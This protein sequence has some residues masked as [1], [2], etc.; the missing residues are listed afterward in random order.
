[1]EEQN[2]A[3]RA[4]QEG[5]NSI[6]R[7]W[8]ALE[9]AVHNQWGGPTSSEKANAMINEVL[10]LFQGSQKIYKDDVSILIEDY[11]ESEFNMVCEDGSPDE[12]GEI[13]VTMFRQCAEGDF[14][15]VNTT[16][17]REK[18]RQNVLASSSG[19]DSGGDVLED[20]DQVPS[21]E[22][23]SIVEEEAKSFEPEVD[24]D[25]FQTVARG[26]RTRS[27]KRYG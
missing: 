2:E 7:Q 18:G 23:N 25:G 8:T 22:L 12:I 15:L 16:I 4:F 11:V 21:T 24:E 1:M 17:E 5:T 14:S 19:L 9:L 26:K 13:I 10:G 20:V 3:I 6:F 27:N